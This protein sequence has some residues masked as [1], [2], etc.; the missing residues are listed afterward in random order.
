MSRVAF[1][2][3]TTSVGRA[4]RS[5]GSAGTR[6]AASAGCPSA[7]VNRPLLAG[8]MLTW[9]LGLAGCAD[10]AVFRDLPEQR[11]IQSAAPGEVLTAA[12][13]LLA[14]EFGRVRVERDG[15]RLV[16]GPVEYVTERDSGSARDLVRGESTMRRTA[17]CDVG[18]RAGATVVSLRIDIERRDTARQIV[19]QPRS[20]RL[21]D[22]PGE[23]SALARDAATTA[24]QNAVWTRV[25]RDRTLERALLDEL[26]ERFAPRDEETSPPP[27]A[28]PASN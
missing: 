6:R 20:Y 23:E 11:V 18:Q 15:R 4:A 10:T 25:R 7:F 5:T 19:A 8:V 17:T 22:S 9:S 27:A 14:R 24:E 13:A 26:R 28:A 12:R 1:E 3:R 21:S 16:G 2:T